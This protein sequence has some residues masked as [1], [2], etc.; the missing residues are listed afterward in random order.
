[1][2]TDRV[3]I[4][5][6]HV[7]DPPTAVVPEPMTVMEG[8][9]VRIDAGESHDPETAV[10]SF[11][12][13]QTAGPVIDLP[14]VADSILEF[15]APMT[16]TDSTVLRFEVTVTDEGGL[17][18]SGEAIVNVTWDNEAPVANA[19][20]ESVVQ[21]GA[22]T[23]KLSAMD[24]YDPDGRIEAFY[25]TQTEGPTVILSDPTAAEPTFVLPPVA[26]EPE[27]HLVFRLKVKDERG[28]EAE[29]EVRVIVTEAGETGF[30]DGE[31]VFLCDTGKFIRVST[32]EPGNLVGLISIPVTA[33]GT[34]VLPYGL[35]EI[36]IKCDVPG[37]PVNLTVDL[38]EPADSEW[39]FLS[40][41][42]DGEWAA[43]ADRSAF[44]QDGKTVTLSL[45]DGGPADQD[46]MENGRILL[47]AAPGEMPASSEDTTGDSDGGGGGTCFIT[48]S[49]TDWGTVGMQVL[50]LLSACLV[51]GLIRR[52]R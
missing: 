32:P 7:N 38:P 10:L 1:E 14:N 31:P 41:K 13:R 34:P 25:W 11:S 4:N 22:G 30:G 9:T 48:A 37:D 51:F 36:V 27:T 21:E 17:Q 8:E 39:A 12:W 20:E 45:V 26:G 46:G 15:T 29:D 52:I 28:L 24:S 47:Q 3:V 19:G 23:Q 6:A 18:A 50:L 2:S 44:T 42:A 43:L 35:M 16:N 49:L 33:E 40:L 5:V